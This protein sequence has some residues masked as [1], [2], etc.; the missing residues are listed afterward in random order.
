MVA[1]GSLAETQVQL[2]QGLEALASCLQGGLGEEAGTA[3]CWEVDQAVG[4]A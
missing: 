1:A 4:I 2:D 3:A